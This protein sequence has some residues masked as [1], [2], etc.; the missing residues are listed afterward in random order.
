MFDNVGVMDGQVLWQLG[1]DELLAALVD[2]ETALRR[3]YGHQ[4]ELLGELLARN[5]AQTQG[6][7]S[8]VH[9]LRDLVRISRAEAQRRS[10]TPR[11]RPLFIR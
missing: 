7:R 5:L 8:P 3:A 2:G 11:Q 9:L 6:Y 1:D 4:L 10:R